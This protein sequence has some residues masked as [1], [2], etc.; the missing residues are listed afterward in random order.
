M[1]DRLLEQRRPFRFGFD[2]RLQRFPFGFFK[3][4]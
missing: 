1:W 2:S 3:T 4:C